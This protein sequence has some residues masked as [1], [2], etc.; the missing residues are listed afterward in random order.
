MD[1]ERDDLGPSSTFLN[2]QR[3]GNTVQTAATRRRQV[4][5]AVMG[6]LAVLLLSLTVSM[7]KVSRSGAVV[8]PGKHSL[9]H[10]AQPA[11]ATAGLVLW[12]ERAD[13]AAGTTRYDLHLTN[14]SG[15]SCTLKGYPKVGA[16]DLAGHGVGFAAQNSQNEHSPNPI[17]IA[18][19]NNATATSMLAITDAAK[20]PGPLCHLKMAAGLR[21]S[22]PNQA[23][24][25]IVPLPFPECTLKMPQIL[26]VESVQK[27]PYSG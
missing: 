11:C 6:F 19:A 5:R 10:S 23:P 25:K 17:S 13:S 22:L 20:F 27:A 18:L 2:V 8:A 12:L 24:G 15:H 3:Q 4:N 9:A 14:L 7:T 16:I 21:V 26:V 1:P